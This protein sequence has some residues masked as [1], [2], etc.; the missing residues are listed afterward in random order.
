MAG[1]GDAIVYDFGGISTVAGQIEAFVADMNQTLA[2]VDKKF[3]NLLTNGWTGAAADAFG[4]LS[5]R[6]H[7][8]ADQM[9][10]TLRRLSTAAGNAAVNMQQA[11]QQA[12]AQFG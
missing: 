7:K 3:T 6:W 4:A 10:N 8:D 2:D 9:A 11:D 12:A 5:Q 1:P